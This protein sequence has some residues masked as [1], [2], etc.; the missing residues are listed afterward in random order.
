MFQSLQPTD[1][2]IFEVTHLLINETVTQLVLWGD[3]GIVVVEL[4]R[5]WG[6]EAK[7]QGGKEVVSCL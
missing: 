4:P 3:L 6:K 7:F 5:R 2:P 1:P